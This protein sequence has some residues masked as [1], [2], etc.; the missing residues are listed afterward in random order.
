MSRTFNN[1]PIIKRHL[2]VENIPWDVL[3]ADC[4]EAESVPPLIPGEFTG[5]AVTTVPLETRRDFEPWAAKYRE[6]V[7]DMVKPYLYWADGY[8]YEDIAQ[9]CWIN[10]YRDN[11]RAEWHI[12]HGYTD[13]VVVWYL[14]ADPSMGRYVY[15]YNGVDVPVE[16]NTGDVLMF[17]GT[18]LHSTEPNTS[19]RDRLIMANN[20]CMTRHASRKL[21]GIMREMDEKRIQALYDERQNG[22]YAKFLL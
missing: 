13:M 20:L 12:H 18:L 10:R 1:Q 15:R 3:N 14:R 8:T 22:I 5:T 16:V 9:G 4:D 7:L 6:L 11:G 21:S 17:P 2:P 19:G